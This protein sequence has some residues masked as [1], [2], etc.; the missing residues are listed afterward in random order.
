MGS[1][2]GIERLSSQPS[3]DRTES[4]SLVQEDTSGNVAG[5]RMDRVGRGEG[6]YLQAGDRV[7]KD[8]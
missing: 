5:G 3:L 4:D 1:S 6:A 8:E 7:T 2:D